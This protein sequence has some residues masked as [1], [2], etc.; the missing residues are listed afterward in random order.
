[1]KTEPIHIRNA[2]SEDASML[3]E[4][5]VQLGYPTSPRQSAYRLQRL[6]NSD[7]H[8]VLIACTA[9]G[10]IVGW[11]HIF[12]TL[13]LE[14]DVCA[15]I[16]GFV[17]AEPHRGCG[18]GS[19]LMKSAEKWVI[20]QNIMKI[21]IRSRSTRLESHNIFVHFGFNAVKEQFVFDKHLR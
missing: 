16:G 6:L 12:L 9:G 15:E 2:K 1:M 10:E 18:I 14:S 19:R 13:R 20:Q 7:G 5:S 17:V 8:L 21:R 11:L 3:A 4:L